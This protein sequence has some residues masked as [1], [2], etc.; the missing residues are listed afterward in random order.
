MTWNVPSNIRIEHGKHRRNVSLCKIFISF[1]NNHRVL[2]AH[3]LVPLFNQNV[4]HDNFP[5]FALKVLWFAHVLTDIEYEIEPAGEAVASIR[6]PH[7]QF[8][9]E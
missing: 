2:L 1:P 7:Q 8:A 5:Q 4:S 6:Y 3:R 9:L